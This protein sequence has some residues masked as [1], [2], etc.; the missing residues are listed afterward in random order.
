M[1]VHEV[2]LQGVHVQLVGRLFGLVTLAAGLQ[3]L[4]LGLLQ[5]LDEA[6]QVRAVLV[7]AEQFGQGLVQVRHA[8]L[9]AAVEA[10][11]A[12]GIE[13]DQIEAGAEQ[14]IAVVFHPLLPAID[15]EHYKTP[16]ATFQRLAVERQ[17]AFIQQGLQQLAD[18]PL[19]HFF[20]DTPIHRGQPGAG[21]GMLA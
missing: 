7:V 12:G 10:F 4:E 15:A 16:L 14:A 19:L 8:A 21:A 20:V 5:F 9:A 2:L 18:H 3:V 13:A 11:Q 6:P 1:G 17:H